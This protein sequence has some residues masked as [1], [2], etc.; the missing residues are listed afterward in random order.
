M[1]THQVV[2]GGVAHE[3][4]EIS[5]NGPIVTIDGPHWFGSGLLIADRYV[6]Q[7]HY[8]QHVNEVAAPMRPVFHVM[9][10]DKSESLFV[11]EAVFPTGCT[12]LLWK[13]VP[14]AAALRP[15]TRDEW[16]SL[17]RQTPCTRADWKLRVV[18]FKNSRGYDPTVVRIPADV[19]CDMASWTADPGVSAGNYF[20]PGCRPIQILG[21]TPLWDAAEFELL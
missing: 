14:V 12:S 6:G 10:T 4:I 20:Y 3:Q 5:I 16:E 1:V 8:K 15:R 19:E 9:L 21:M 2:A 7:A 13:P 18:A 17:L 11:G